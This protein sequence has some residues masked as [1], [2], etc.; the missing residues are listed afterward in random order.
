MNTKQFAQQII[1]ALPP[2]L[3]RE[4]GRFLYSPPS[5]VKKGEIYL[6]GINPGGSTNPLNDTIKKH[7]TNM[8]NHSA[9]LDEKWGKHEKGMNPLQ[10]R[11][12]SLVDNLGLKLYDVCASNLIYVS[13]RNEIKLGGFEEFNKWADMCWDAHEIILKIVQPKAIVIFGNSPFQ[14]LSKKA[15]SVEW[16][17]DFSSGHG[18]WK[19][20]AFVGDFSGRRIKVLGV[21]HFSRF[22]IINK[23][24]PIDWI[25]KH[26]Q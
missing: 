12:R 25:K 4:N 9:Y 26:L 23:S 16:L 2:E 6:L 3:L 8:A 18:N 17:P 1:D 5:S 10:K 11:V 19:C 13:S 15:E 7:I 20:R 21:P 14:Y 22:N 24:D